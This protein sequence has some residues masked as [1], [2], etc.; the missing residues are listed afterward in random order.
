MFGSKPGKLTNQLQIRKQ[1]MEAARKGDTKEFE[2]L[3]KL[4]KEAG[5]RNN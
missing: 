4:F 5:N 2:R 3:M 1:A